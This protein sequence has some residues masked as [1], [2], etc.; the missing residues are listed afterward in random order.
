MT[1]RSVQIWFQNRRQRLLKPL[2]Q[3][4]GARGPGSPPSSESGEYPASSSDGG[5]SGEAA[6]GARCV[7]SSS[8]PQMAAQLASMFAPLM[9]AADGA[10][11]LPASAPLSRLSSVWAESLGGV[12][13]V[14][15]AQYAMMLQRPLDL[16]PNV[17]TQL[18][19]ALQPPAAAHATAAPAAG[20]PQQT[21]ATGGTAVSPPPSEGQGVDGL[22]LLSACADAH[23]Q[24]PA[25]SA[26]PRGVSPPPLLLQD[27]AKLQKAQGGATPG[28]FDAHSPTAA[29]MMVR[30]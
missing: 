29:P 4:D 20:L 8:N 14:T 2:R 22:L 17:A 19:H 11:E 21:G 28:M 30:A 5:E 10:A 24:R 27:Y 3:N 15:A 13:A 12:E 1:P 7:A 16:P 18:A 6:G 26:P 23:A 9:R 25:E